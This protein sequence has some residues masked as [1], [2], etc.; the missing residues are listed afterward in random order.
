MND[1]NLPLTPINL[2]KYISIA[3]GCEVDFNL[4]YDLYVNTS[5]G[6]LITNKLSNDDFEDLYGAIKKGY[7]VK[8]I[9]T[10]KALN[11]TYAECSE[12]VSDDFKCVVLSF[13][14]NSKY[15]TLTLSKFG[16]DVFLDDKD[17]KE[18]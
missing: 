16:T 4:L 7:T 8:A 11:I 6:T 2:E 3:L 12:V 13:I 17:V 1:I 5:T 9:T 14:H 18:L 15:V 10:N